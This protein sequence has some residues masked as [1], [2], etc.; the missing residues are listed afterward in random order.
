MHHAIADGKALF[1]FFEAWSSTCKA[2]ISGGTE[3]SS[4]DYGEPIIYDRA[5]L[6]K[7]PKAEEIVRQFL[8]CL[9]PN[10]PMVSFSCLELTTSLIFCV[11][12][13]I[14]Q[15]MGRVHRPPKEREHDSLGRRTFVL[16]APSVRSLKQ[17]AA[18]HNTSNSTS[19]RPPS[20]FSAISAHVWA[21]IVRSSKSF[22]PDTPTVLVVPMDCRARL[23]P[24]IIDQDYFGNCIRPVFATTTAGELIGVDGLVN[25]CTALGMSID[26]VPEDPL[27]DCES[28]AADLEAK[29]RER[30]VFVSASPRF[31]AYDADFGWGR[32]GRFELVSMNNDGQFALYAGRAEG[33]VQV[34]VTLAPNQME[35][36]AEL[37]LDGLTGPIR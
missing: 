5:L 26:G 18:R 17:R 37:F 7:H 25:A 2:M 22:E 36:F 13:Y 20:T 24:P 11:L 1:R 23:N 29:L 30:C 9:A 32:P 16:N 3:S 35:T 6:M 28:W 8:R 14:S 10:L 15:Q 31:R 4:M 21:C 33:T 27:S 12:I 34:S 19:A